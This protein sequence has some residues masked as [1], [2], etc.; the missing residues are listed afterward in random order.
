MS[1]RGKNKCGLGQPYSLSIEINEFPATPEI[2]HKGHTLHSSAADGNQWFLNDSLLVGANQQDLDLLTD[3]NYFSMVT[4]NG[5]TSEPSNIIDIH[6][7]GIDQLTRD[8]QSLLFPNPTT[9]VFTVNFPSQTSKIQIYSMEGSL[10]QEI[11]NPDKIR[12]FKC[13]I[14]ES[15][16]YFIRIIVDHKVLTQKVVINQN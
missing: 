6:N 12:S 11:L 5:C 15:G 9:G 16:I 8:D 10:L 13:F 14:S 7:S 3:G 1:V 4:L 2:T